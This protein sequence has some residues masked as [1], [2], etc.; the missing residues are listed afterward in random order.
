MRASDIIW[1]KRVRRAEPK[2][3]HWKDY[4]CPEGNGVSEHNES[5][6]KWKLNEE[7]NNRELEYQRTQSNHTS[8]EKRGYIGEVF[9][10]LYFLILFGAL[11]LATMYG[12]SILFEGV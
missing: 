12:A 8:Y 5:D 9:A 3:M 1:K 6:Y 4:K 7:S 10:L 2:R 11:V